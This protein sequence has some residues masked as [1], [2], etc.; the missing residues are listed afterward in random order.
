M[1]WRADAT[2]FKEVL[3]LR[4][5]ISWIIRPCSIAGLSRFFLCIHQQ[6]I[7]SVSEKAKSWIREQ[8]YHTRQSLRHANRTTHT[9][10]FNPYSSTCAYCCNCASRSLGMPELIAL[11]IR[12]FRSDRLMATLADNAAENGLMSPKVRTSHNERVCRFG[13]G[14]PQMITSWNLRHLHGGVLDTVRWVNAIKQRPRILH[15]SR[16][17][18]KHYQSTKEWVRSRGHAPTHLIR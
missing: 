10:R 14:C 16:E 1:A 5:T 12:S 15:E 3:E 9:H 4:R 18:R 13:H 11:D 17:K 6:G 7:C 2:R 8:R